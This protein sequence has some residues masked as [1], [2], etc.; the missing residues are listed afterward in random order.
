LA[1]LLGVL[2]DEL[3]DAVDEGVG[4]ACLDGASRQARSSSTLARAGAAEALGELDE[5]LGGVG[6]AVE[7]DVLDAVAELGVDV[8]VDGELAGVDD[9]HVEAGLDGVVEEGGV[10]GLADGSLPRKEKEML[11]TP[12][13][14]LGPGAARVDP[15]VGW[16]R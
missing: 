13:M 15:A 14:M 12:P 2:F 7:E 6:A 1:G 9:A 16:R 4:E 8:L 10:H 11:L 5:A 3:D